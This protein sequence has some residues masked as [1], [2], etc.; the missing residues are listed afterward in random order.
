MKKPMKKS[1]ALGAPAERDGGRGGSVEGGVPTGR[2][3]SGSESWKW[4][5]A[6]NFNLLP[7][8]TP[9]ECAP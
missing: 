8:P 4:N 6:D 5:E 9:P 7:C 1:S 2:P 3:N